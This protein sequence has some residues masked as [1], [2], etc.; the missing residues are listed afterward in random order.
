MSGLPLPLV[1]Y[2]IVCDDILLDPSC[3]NKPLLVGVTSLIV[4]AG[5]PPYP[6][7]L[8]KLCVY[9]VLTEGRG[10]GTVQLRLI[11][12]DDE[13][14]IWQTPPRPVQFG[15]DPLE[16]TGLVFRVE[17]CRFPQPGPYAL[18]LLFNGECIGQQ[19]LRAR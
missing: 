12:E 19:P 7:W 6:F 11:S 14:E 2:L 8:E 9:A 15:P 1:H 17:R 16:I 4:P 18:Q 3:P 5:D 13:S 10:S